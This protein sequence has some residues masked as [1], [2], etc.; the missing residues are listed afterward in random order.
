MR[1][2]AELWDQMQLFFGQYN[3]HQVHCAIYLEHHLEIERIGKAV[4]RSMEAVPILK[5]RFAERGLR[6]CW[7]EMNVCEEDVIDI[8]ESSSEEEEV[9]L[10]LTQRTDEFQG[11]QLMVR[12]IRSPQRDILCIVINHMVCDAQGFKEYLYLLSYTYTRLNKTPHY[13]PQYNADGSRSIRQIFRQ[14]HFL[15]R[16]KFLFMPDQMDQYDSGYRFPMSSEK[17]KPFI[18]RHRL[19]PERFHAL[20]EFSRAKHVTINDIVLTAYIRSL[21]Q[22]LK[23]SGGNS[24]AIPCAMD[25]RRF[26]TERQAGAIC[27]LT[28]MISCDI[29]LHTGESFLETLGKVKSDMDEKKRNI[30]LS[31]NGPAKLHALFNLLPYSIIKKAVRQAFINPFIAMT[32]IGIIDKEQLAFDDVPVLDAFVTGSIKYP[33]YFQ[34]ALSSF[35]ESITFTVNLYGSQEDKERI[36]NFLQMVVDELPQ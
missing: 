10:F 4:L 29:E 19:T 25:L 8:V 33:P 27:N 18:I 36:E 30:N 2:R 34:I 32:N 23:I 7:E 13:I 31:L 9:E 22:V 20:R 3:D 24:L 16:L 5:C 28:S 21:C 1:Y 17:G 14:F 6:P 35:D 15:D 26:L 11:P 12:V